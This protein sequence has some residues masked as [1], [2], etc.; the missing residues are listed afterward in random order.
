MERCDLALAG[1]LLKCER[2]LGLEVEPLALGP[3]L[4]LE[5]LTFLLS[6]L[7][8]FLSHP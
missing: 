7:L 8:F 5:G 6:S 1:S 3:A 2:T 4:K